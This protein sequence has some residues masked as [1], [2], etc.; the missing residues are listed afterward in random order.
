[1]AR[2][3]GREAYLSDV[4][5]QI[6]DNLRGKLRDELYRVLILGLG[7]PIQRLNQR[8]NVVNVNLAV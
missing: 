4:V 2:L 5:N 3:D 6:Q 8:V 7:Y 1:V